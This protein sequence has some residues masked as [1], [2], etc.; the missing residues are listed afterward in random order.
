MNARRVVRFQASKSFVRSLFVCC[1][2][3]F[4]Q[5]G[6]AESRGVISDSAALRSE[7]SSDAA[8]TATVKAGE[9]FAF[10]CEKAADWCKVTLASGQSGWLEHSRIRLY[11]TEKDL[12][13]RE[14]RSDNV[15]EIDQFA[16]GRG[17][18]YAAVTRRAARGDPKALKQF[19]LL[20]QAADGAAAES[21][22]DVPTIVYHLVGDAKFSAF[23]NA[24]PVAF[25]TMVRNN[26]LSDGRTPSDTLYLRRHFPETTKVVFRQEMV[27]WFSPDGLYA[28]RKVFSDEF[29]LSGSKVKRAELIDRKSGRVLCDLTPDDIG[30]GAQREGAVL[31]SPDSKH[32]AS[33]SSNE[34]EHHGNLFSTP[35]PE[36]YRKQTVVYQ[37]VGET[38]TRVD[39]PLTEVPGRK[40]DAELH[41]AILGHEYIEPV[42][43]LKPNVLLLQRHEYYEK[44]KPLTVGDSKFNTIHAFDRLYEIT[45]SISLDAKAVV[46]WKL[47]KDRP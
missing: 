19:L 38:F 13:V 4:A 26:F 1:V 35:R 25:R 39:V 23:L 45:V 40:D 11:F 30:A 21:I 8:V 43:W 15:S 10:E 24:Q 12:P 20:A 36:P 28:I 31:W 46:G 37:L 2:L 3:A 5:T 18:D 22:A 41:D 29:D 42:R 7:Q 6:S 14:K 33:L 44:L 34:P 17:L 16:R 27:D 9:P 32:V 47:R